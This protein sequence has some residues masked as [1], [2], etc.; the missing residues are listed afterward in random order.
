MRFCL[1][2][3]LPDTAVV[4]SGIRGNFLL[5]PLCVRDNIDA[6][7]ECQP[8]DN[9]QERAAS[10]TKERQG[11]PRDRGKSHTHSY[12]FRYLKPYPSSNGNNN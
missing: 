11:K 5:K 9:S 12:T 4:S 6:L 8:H 3:I 1:I 10:I 2:K 7:Y